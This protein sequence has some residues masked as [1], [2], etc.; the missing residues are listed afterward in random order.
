[1]TFN[2]R[3]C[4]EVS[5]DRGILSDMSAVTDRSYHFSQGVYDITV[6]S[7][8]YLTAPATFVAQDAPTEELQNA[9]AGSDAPS[10]MVHL[11]KNIPLIRRGEDLILFDVGAGT[12]YQP[13][14]GLLLGNLR[15]SG[16]DPASITKV[17]L[18]HAHPDHLWGMLDL[19]NRLNYPN[20]AYYIGASEWNFWMAP[21]VA[22]QLPENFRS[23]VPESQQDLEAINERVTFIKAGDEIADGIRV[24]GTP[25]HTPGHLSFELDGGSG[26]IITADAITHE[27][28]SF[29]HPTWRNGFDFDSRLAIQTR[30]VFLDRAS[31]D[32][33]KLLGF[34]FPYPGTGFSEAANGA[35]RFIPVI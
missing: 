26:L 13:T 28:I 15:V 31:A 3:V 35:F 11:K 6:L 17:V 23:I 5:D 2:N 21:D 29:E 4:V 34:H 33:I 18:T 27:I 22:L 10:S 24:I 30:K 1:V 8:G 19:S 16:V 20:A 7:D 25:G 9:L 32:G 14:E 12:K